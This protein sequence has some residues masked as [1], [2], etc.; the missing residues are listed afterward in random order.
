[1]YSKTYNV[2]LEHLSLDKSPIT[3]TFIQRDNTQK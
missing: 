2:V 1:M 3:F